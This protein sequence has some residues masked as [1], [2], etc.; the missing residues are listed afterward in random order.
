MTKHLAAALD[1]SKVSDRDASRIIFAAADAFNIDP[2]N[3]SA[4]VEN[5]RRNRIKKRKETAEEVRA[6]FAQ[7]NA[8][9]TFVLHWDGKR[10]RNTT[11]T[12]TDTAS[13]DTQVDRLAIILSFG[14]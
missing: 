2:S 9:A 5:V 7:D 4:S 14:K 11:A 3:V 10:L 13:T 6:K 1:R 12:E 8:N